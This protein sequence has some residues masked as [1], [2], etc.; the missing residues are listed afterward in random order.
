METILVDKD[1]CTRCGICSIVCPMAIVSPVDE[2]TLPVVQDAMAGM[3]IQCGHCE[4]SCPSQALLLNVRPDEKVPL[5]AGAGTISPDDIGTYLKKRRSVRHFTKDPVPKEKILE[6]LDIARYAASGGNGQPV[7]WIV[8]HDPE[9]VKKIAGQTI[10][11]IKTLQNTSHPMSGY[12]PVLIARWESGY[13]VVCRDAPHLLCAHIPEG[14]P[15]ASVDAIIA[16]THFDIAAPAFGIGTCWAGF[17]AMAASS[18]EPLQKEL[19]IPA[20]RKSAYA[21]M[22]GHPQY[23]IYGIPRRKPLEVTWL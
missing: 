3:C 7:Q 21:M 23:K 13:D 1:L 17:V 6:I 20:G 22:F 18:Y 14:N 10:E 9:K 19:G 15:M 2:N 8:V 4:V 12:I 5:P 16:L 11:W